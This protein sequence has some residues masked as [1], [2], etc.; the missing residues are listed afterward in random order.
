MLENEMNTST[1]GVCTNCG[2][3]CDCST[4]NCENCGSEGTCVCK[5]G[6]DHDH[7]NEI[8]M[9]NQGLESEDQSMD[10]NMNMES[11]N[12]AGDT[13]SS[14]DTSTGD[15]NTGGGSLLDKIKNLFS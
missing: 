11:E 8:E 1:G 6:T 10:Q 7:G 4:P 3:D 5:P 9:K 15:Q 14:S 2:G 12:M 13:S